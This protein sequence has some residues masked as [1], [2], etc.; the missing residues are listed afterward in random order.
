M[1]TLNPDQ[2]LNRKAM[3]ELAFRVLGDAGAAMSMSL[4]YIGVKLDLFNTLAAAGRASSLEVAEKARLDERYVREWLKAMVAAEYIEYDAD[5]DLYYM[6]A[7]QG[8]VLTRED[9]PVFVGGAFQLT[10]PS[11]LNVPRLME[12]FQDGTGIPYKEIG[13]DVAEAI[14][15]MFRPGYTHKL[16]QEWIPTMPD[17]K[18]KLEDGC[19]VLDLGC[20]NGQSTVA[21]AKAYPKSKIIG[22]DIDAP[23]IER[24]EKL[25]QSNRLTNC[26]F[27]I[28]PAH[29]A[30]AKE[31]FDLICAFDCI[32]DMVKPRE[33]L[34]FIRESL[35]DD[36]VFFWI[37]PNASDNPLENRNL[38]GRVYASISPHHCLTVSLAHGGEGLGTTIGER[39][40]KRLA[41][42]CG[43]SSFERLPIDDAMN[44]FFMAK[45]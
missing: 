4:G 5:A 13:D 39:G 8:E 23:S 11:I 14:E 21:L 7:E 27:V 34:K 45:K 35:S 16:A 28:A 40:A 36:G 2:Q 33:T 26:Q 6:T 9:S 18:R 37:E 17:I 1:T 42:E 30:P 12:V 22:N 38:V 43:F 3:Y 15:K 19:R 44:M 29:E 25:A 32:H 10:I 31:K 20:G 41:E 24:A